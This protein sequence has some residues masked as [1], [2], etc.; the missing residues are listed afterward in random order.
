MLESGSLTTGPLSSS[1]SFCSSA[2]DSIDYFF[3]LVEILLPQG[4]TPP[5]VFSR[6]D[7]RLRLRLEALEGVM[8]AL[9]AF[10]GVWSSYL[11]LFLLGA[12]LDCEV[13]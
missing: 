9:R 1:E 11:L 13:C 10:I 2:K 3:L 7:L 8:D 4:S 12:S 5:L 6:A